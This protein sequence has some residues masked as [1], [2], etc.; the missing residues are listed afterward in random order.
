MSTGGTTPTISTRSVVLSGQELSTVVLVLAGER[1]SSAASILG[2][3]TNTALAYIRSARRKFHDAG[4]IINNVVDVERAFSELRNSG[5][6]DVRDRNSQSLIT[7]AGDHGSTKKYRPG[8][9]PAS[10]SSST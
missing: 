4:Y 1:V 9:E 6:L 3:T 7:L 2:I 8:D 5:R 10:P